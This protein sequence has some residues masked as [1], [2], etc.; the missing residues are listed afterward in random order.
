LLPSFG[1]ILRRKE[2]GGK[3]WSA[4]E[5]AVVG[6]GGVDHVGLLLKFASGKTEL[7]EPLKG[8]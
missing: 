3:L 4:L 1:D 7:Y 2:R 6:G 8:L 5:S